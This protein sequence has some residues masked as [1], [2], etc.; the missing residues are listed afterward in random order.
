MG[1]FSKKSSGTATVNH[2]GAKAFSLTPEVELATILLT[3]FV[4]DKTYET[5]KDNLL[6]LDRIIDSLK[7]KQFAGKAA[8]F[9]RHEFGMRSIT[10]VTAAMLANKVKGST[11]LRPL[12]SDLVYRPDD[13]IEIFAYYGNE[14]GKPFP[15]VLKRGL[16]DSLNKFDAYQLAKYRKDNAEVK[17]VDLFNIIH[18]KPSDSKASETF[19]KLVEGN[20]KNKTTW[21]SKISAAGKNENKESAKQE[22]WAEMIDSGK[23]GYMAL[24]RNLRNIVQDCPE[25]IAKVCELLVDRKAIKS[26]KQF[27]YRFA[28]AYKVIRDMGDPKVNP[29]LNAISAALDISVEN[30]PG[31]DG[32]NAIAIDL[33]ASMNSPMSSKSEMSLKEVGALMGAIALKKNPNS[34]VMGFGQILK[35]ANILA[36]D[37]VLTI[38][39]QIMKMNVGHSTNGYL[40]PQY[41]KAQKIKVDS[42]MLFSDMQMWDSGANYWGSD[43][44]FNPSYLAYK[45]DFPDVRLYSFDLTG[46]GTLQTPQKNTYLVA[47]FSDKIF[48]LFKYL[49]DGVD[50]LVKRINEYQV[51]K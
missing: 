16:R 5:S 41:L 17:M 31:I 44:E 49:N 27:P 19:K 51:T 26:S 32:V 22:A 4:E 3:S 2:E 1:K 11:W 13:A 45:K 24:L 36:G 30:V 8:I 50:Q 25:K 14:Y 40:V 9:A 29:I 35:V 46:Y 10:H 39:D 15:N 47:G 20:L 23:L 38:A 43:Q 37:S 6:R 21:E 33:S 48:D 42:I 34:I 18:P 7:D 12:I 28:S